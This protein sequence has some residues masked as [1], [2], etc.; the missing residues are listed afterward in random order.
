M[1]LLWG[2]VGGVCLFARHPVH[3][4]ISG[5]QHLLCRRAFELAHSTAYLFSGCRPR[6]VE[7]DRITFQRPV[8]VG[9][10]ISFRAWVTRAWALPDTPGQVRAAHVMVVGQYP[11]ILKRMLL[12][13]PRQ[14]G[15][16]FAKAAVRLP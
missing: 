4:N 1:V 6:T 8:S 5:V 15:S 2:R 12:L 10:L 3:C 13:V 14:D 7:V 9:D 11:D 16:W